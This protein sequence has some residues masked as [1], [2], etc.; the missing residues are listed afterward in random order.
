[1]KKLNLLIIWIFLSLFVA[2][3]SSS[4]EVETIK[5]SKLEMCPTATVEEMVDRFFGDPSWESDITDEDIKFVNI[6]GD[7][8]YVEKPVRAVIQFIF[9]KDETSFEY[10]AFEING[11]PQNQLIAEALLKKC[12]R[13]QNEKAINTFS[14]FC[15][16]T[17]KWY[18]SSI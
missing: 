2:G 8:T 11:V 1:M 16:S 12:V 7:I 6:G 9:S 15:T 3:C 10:Q 5:Q 4:Q 18:N 13:V 17:S 14:N